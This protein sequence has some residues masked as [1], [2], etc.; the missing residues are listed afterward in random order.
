VGNGGAGGSE[1]YLRE[2][3]ISAM[4]AEIYLQLIQN[5]IQGR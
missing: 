5:S 4:V 3:R 1:I 2:K